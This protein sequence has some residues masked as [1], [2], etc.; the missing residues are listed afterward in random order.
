MPPLITDIDQLHRWITGHP[1]RHQQVTAHSCSC[2]W[3]WPD[4]AE[5]LT[6]GWATW[7]EHSDACILADLGD[8]LPSHVIDDKR[9]IAWREACDGAY[10]CVD[11]RDMNCTCDRTDWPA[12]TAV[13]GD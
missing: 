1:E 7:E 8:V 11:W 4:W 6:D 3:A 2:G 10:A 9:V 5:A 12:P 13:E